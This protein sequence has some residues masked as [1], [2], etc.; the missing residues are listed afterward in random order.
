MAK[1]RFSPLAGRPAFFFRFPLFV[2]IVVCLAVC[3]SAQDAGQSLAATQGVRTTGLI[4]GAVA[5]VDGANITMAGGVVIDISKARLFSAGGG[6]PDIPIKPGM[7]IRAIIVGADDASSAL[8][9]DLVRVQPEDE[10][11]FS[12]L[13]QAVDL[14]NG[15]ITM[16][17]RRI[18]MTD[19]TS[20][21][22]KRRKLKVGLLVSVIAKAKGADLVAVTILPHVFLP[23]IFP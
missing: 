19:E 8:V 10:I 7:S 13:V 17:N 2:S 20:I 4:E 6:H 22:I 16:I 18:L 14:D 3:A 21:P 15:S 9:A 5:G 23:T 1:Y 11:I 12:G